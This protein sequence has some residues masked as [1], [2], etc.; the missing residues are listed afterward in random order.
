MRNNHCALG[1]S[2]RAS[3]SALELTTGS[4]KIMKQ[5]LV[6]LGT[7]A[8]VIPAVLFAEPS[9]KKDLTGVWEVSISPT[10]APPPPLRALSMFRKDGSFVATLNRK[11]PS[12][13]PI[14]AVAVEMGPA[15]GRW[16]QTSDREFQLT[17]Y[18]AMWNKGGDNKWISSYPGYHC[19]VRVR[20]RVHS[21]DAGR[22]F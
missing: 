17:S 7:V 22:F 1:D 20:R 3:G 15:Y 6:A 21:Q 13:P 14:Q 18:T 11:A 12:A 2:A 10:G 8:L 16:V 9:E 5:A 4:S 19:L